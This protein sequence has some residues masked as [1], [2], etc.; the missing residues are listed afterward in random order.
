MMSIF[1]RL[2]DPYNAPV[3]HVRKPG[4]D[5]EEIIKFEEDDPFL[6]EVSI[7]V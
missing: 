4:S 3:L 5:L 2:I 1:N 6:S 7:G